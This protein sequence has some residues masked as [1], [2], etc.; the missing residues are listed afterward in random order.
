[1]E[2]GNRKNLNFTKT[3]SSPN[4]KDKQLIINLRYDGLSLLSCEP[5][6]KH[7]HDIA[8]SSWLP[9]R[10]SAYLIEEADKFFEEHNIIL[11]EAAGINWLFSVS[12]HALIPDTLY[13]QGQGH[14]ILEKTSRLESDESVYSDFWAHRDIVGLYA[15][16]DSLYQW[17]N[18]K[19]EKSSVAHSS[20]AL[21]SL[22]GKISNDKE[23]ALLQLGTSF[24]E[25][26]I[27]NSETVIF[28]NQFG[29]DV[30]E[31]LLYYLLFALEQNRILPTELE[32]IVAG[33]IL[34]GSPLYQ[35]LSTYIGKITE[36]PIP[37]GVICAAHL[38]RN[39]QRQVAHLI[40]SL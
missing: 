36:A 27:A 22:S 34:K 20:F 21:N 9:S 24:A 15:I 23:F 33:N 32:L 10:E 16:S 6:G 14:I 19:N 39:Q 13:Q 25:L 30:N 18:S 7:I 31:D 8:Q 26:F 40:A 4:V 29:F 12:K 2:T 5:A 3:S 17:A 37:A 28:Y 1:M 38:T 11:T 35:L